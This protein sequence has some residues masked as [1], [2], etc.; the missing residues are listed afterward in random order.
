MSEQGG[1]WK[2]RLYWENEVYIVIEQKSQDTPVYK[3]WSKSGTTK[4]VL[5][6]NLLLPCIYFPVEKAD[7]RPR[8]KD[9]AR[10]W[11]QKPSQLSRQLN[12][13][14]C[15]ATQT[16]D[17]EDIPPFT[18]AQTQVEHLSNTVKHPEK[19]DFF[20]WQCGINNVNVN[21]VKH[22][23]FSKTTNCTRLTGSCM[24][25]VRKIASYWIW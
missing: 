5:H 19:E 16:D 15:T 13:T 22:V 1:P 20:F 18:P 2:L 7:V 25:L 17:G 21:N 23:N 12:W 3:V 8:D 11:N 9:N 14:T 24:F 4:R 6:C 10:Q